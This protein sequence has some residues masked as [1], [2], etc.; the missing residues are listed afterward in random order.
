MRGGASRAWVFDYDWAAD[1]E[2]WLAQSVGAF[3]RLRFRPRIPRDVTAVSTE[4]LLFGRAVSMP[5][6]LGTTGFT[7]MLHHAGECAVA[8]AAQA[9]G[10][11]YKTGSSFIPNG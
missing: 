1:S 3:T 8:Q 9:V 5:L 2:V 10:L 7:R 6:V 11:P 4:T